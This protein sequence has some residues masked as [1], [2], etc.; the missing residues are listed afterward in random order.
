MSS[1]SAQNSLFEIVVW[2]VDNS[3]KINKELVVDLF[4][5]APEYYK[6][7]WSKLLQESPAH[8]VIE[9]SLILFILWLVFIRKTV[10]PSKSS[11]NEKLSDK[12][13]EW[14]LETW[15]PDP[16]VPPLTEKDELLVDNVPIITG[17]KGD[18]IEVEGVAGPVLNVS[19]FDF[20]ALSRDPDIKQATIKALDFYG[21]G[22]CGPRGFYGTIDQH[23]FFEEAIA[24]FCGS[25]EAISYS[26]SASAVSSVIPAFSKKG[27]LILVDECCW[28]AVQTG[29]NLSR[30]TV[31]FFRHN[32]VEHLTAILESIADD[33]KKLKRDLTQQ[34]R[35]IVVEGLYRN[36]GDLCPL[37]EIVE[38]KK[39]FRYRL[40]LDESMSFGSV[41]ATGRGVTEHFGVDIKEVE[42]LT[43]SMDTSLASVGGVCI[44]EHEVVDHQRLSGAGYCF[45]AAAPPFLSAA[46]IVA[47]GKM[48]N[49]PR[50]LTELHQNTQQLYD[51]LSRSVPGFKVKSKEAMPII[52]LELE[53]PLDT[54][55]EEASLMMKIA[56]H[57]LQGGIG[58][59]ASKST[60][61]VAFRPSLMVCAKVGWSKAQ[62]SKI[63]KVIGQA[64]KELGPA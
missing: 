58:V 30:S 25:E 27:D 31:Q 29:V 17:F 45:S 52:H 54:L 62:I 16:L 41:G 35:F 61:S 57:C 39:K 44:G 20:L 64:A 51:Q 40:I 33:D 5:N 42:V 32:D 9:T 19:A 60:P 47:L 22:S 55:D 13:V 7:W 15:T 37:R 2:V 36:V 1:T 38:L 21:C 34:R 46:A 6:F 43:L 4:Y 28:D 23:L 8:I 14:L 10:D 53:I 3:K 49:E 24:K 56:N 63:V 12:E 18:S 59:V 48:A 26:D 50:L 11:K